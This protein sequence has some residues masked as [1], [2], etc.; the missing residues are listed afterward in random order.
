MQV[1]N[2]LEDSMAV[3]TGWHNECEQHSVACFSMIQFREGRTD[4]QAACLQCAKTAMVLTYSLV[5]TWDARVGKQHAT[6]SQED[7]AEA[8]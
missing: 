1:D 2:S 7:L 8:I 6:E 5:S 4:R 3:Q